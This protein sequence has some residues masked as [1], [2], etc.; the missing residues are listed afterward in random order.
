[1]NLYDLQLTLKVP[2][3]IGGRRLC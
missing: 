3:V 1:M 2:S